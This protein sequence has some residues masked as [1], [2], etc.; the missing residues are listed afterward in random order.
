MAAAHCAASWRQSIEA[1][2]GV[3]PLS[4]L[5]LSGL[6]DDDFQLTLERAAAEAQGALDPFAGR[7]MRVVYFNGGPS[8]GSRLQ[9]VIHHWCVDLY[10]WQIFL[11]DLQTAYRAR[12][13]RPP[14][15]KT[16]EAPKL[17]PKTTS[18]QAWSQ[19]LSNYAKQRPCPMDPTFWL[20][21]ADKQ[22]AQLPL[23]GKPGGNVERSAAEATGKL[24]MEESAAFLNDA[25][26]TFRTRVETLLLAT[27]AQ[28]LSAWS[29]GRCFMVDLEG[30]GREPLF[31]DCDLSR[32]LGWF[33]AIYPIVLDLENRE[34]PEEIVQA[35]K[36]HLSAVP[37]GGIDYGLLRYLADDRD[38]R[39]RLST[40]RAPIVFSYAGQRQSGQDRDA[41]LRPA[42]ERGGPPRDPLGDREYWFHINA[43]VID[44][45]LTLSWGYS[46]ALHR[47]ET[48]ER[49][50][51][52]WL[53][54]LRSLIQGSGEATAAAYSPSDFPDMDF[55]QDE[56]DDLIPA[57][58]QDDREGG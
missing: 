5:D 35:V 38:I 33:T 9:I 14:E 45:R 7:L 21:Q 50:V 55:S 54:A 30:H 42:P 51:D 47:P 48:C 39:R 17:P 24:S 41:W 44:K 3:A 46:A 26:S 58:I 29:G 31:E 25:T 1:F 28:T 49:L 43:A 10:S 18:I 8:N 4:W 34:R 32:T 40:Q 15:R 2:D 13:V 19:R 27:L 56:L 12:L 37:N 23:D 6:S 52:L 20:A 22:V 57:L 11:E 53:D 36:E 16:G